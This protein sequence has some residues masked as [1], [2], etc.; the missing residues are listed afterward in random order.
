MRSN[1]PLIFIFVICL[2]GANPLYHN[3]VWAKNDIEVPNKISIQAQMK[4]YESY[5]IEWEDAPLEQK[6]RFM[7]F[8]HEHKEEVVKKEK[9][10]QKEQE[11]IDKRR[12]EF[13]EERQKFLERQER[14]KKKRLREEKKKKR[15]KESIKKKIERSQKRFERWQKEID[16]M[17]DD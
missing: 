16:K 12:E 14:L 3:P 9:K 1:N 13:E 7:K 15:E 2:I 8:Y 11:K 5:G 6:M 17:H 10:Y 4:F